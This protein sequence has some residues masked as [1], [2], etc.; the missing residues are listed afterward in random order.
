MD[1]TVGNRVYLL[2]DLERGII[3]HWKITKIEGDVLTLTRC[4]CK[5]SITVKSNEVTTDAKLTRK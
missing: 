3:Y 5:P 4:K 2:K 1:L